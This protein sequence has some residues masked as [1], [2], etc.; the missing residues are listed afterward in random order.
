MDIFRLCLNTVL[1][2]SRDLGRQQPL[3]HQRSRIFTLLC[4][5]L[6]KTSDQQ[7]NWTIKVK[8]KSVWTECN[9]LTVLKGSHPSLVL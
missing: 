3:G 8:Y 6:V 4:T 9:S 1:S 2:W 7:D 5:Y